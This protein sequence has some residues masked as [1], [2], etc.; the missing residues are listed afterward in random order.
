M[1]R[2]NLILIS[3]RPLKNQFSIAPEAIAWKIEFNHRYNR[4]IDAHWARETGR[5]YLC[6]RSRRRRFEARLRAGAARTVP[7]GSP[8]SNC[9]RPIEVPRERSSKTTTIQ[10]LRGSPARDLAPPKQDDPRLNRV[11][12]WFSSSL[13]LACGRDRRGMKI[14]RHP[15]EFHEH[16]HREL[17]SP[18][19]R[20][21]KANALAPRM[22]LD[23]A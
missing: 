2:L 7:S 1:I 5:D 11:V 4:Y 8:R 9:H 23:P 12:D 19:P 22:G 17:R 20:A 14:A 21:G 15:N 16:S 13:P 18:Y 6:C 10:G 3:A